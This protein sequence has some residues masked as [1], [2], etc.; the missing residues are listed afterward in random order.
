[1]FDVR[2][3]LLDTSALPV[4]EAINFLFSTGRVITTREDD[5]EVVIVRRRPS[6][7]VEG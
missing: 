2:E 3:H 7:Q 4:D 5:D 1:M 6:P